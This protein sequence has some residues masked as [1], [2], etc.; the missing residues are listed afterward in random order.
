M[1]ILLYRDMAGIEFESYIDVDNRQGICE[2]IAGLDQWSLVGQFAFGRAP[3]WV[4]GTHSTQVLVTKRW[5]RS[6][7]LTG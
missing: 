4:P 6:P 2:F 5:H 1:L 7:H 3:W